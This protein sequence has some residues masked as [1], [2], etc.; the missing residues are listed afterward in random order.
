MQTSAE[1]SA[2]VATARIEGTFMRA[3]CCAGGGYVVD[4]GAGGMFA[5]N[6]ASG[7]EGGGAGTIH[8]RT[9]DSGGG[10]VYERG[11]SDRGGTEAGAEGAAKS[12]RWTGG[13]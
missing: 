5:A 2:I 10:G 8:G 9:E 3:R 4:S 1:R 7:A 6:G 13:A 11:T 12:L